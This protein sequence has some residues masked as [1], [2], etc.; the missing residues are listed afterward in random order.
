MLFIITI[1]VIKTAFYLVIY[2]SKNRRV[3]I[4]D[5]EN[6]IKI[7]KVFI[8]KALQDLFKKNTF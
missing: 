3:I 6:L 1:H 7:Y 4:K 5:I 8:S 2:S